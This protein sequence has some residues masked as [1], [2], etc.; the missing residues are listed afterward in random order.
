MTSREIIKRLKKEGW[1]L[2]HVKGSHHQ[3]KHPEKLGKITVPHPEKDFP[4]GTLKNIF[5]MA[6][7]D[8]PINKPKKL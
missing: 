5:R 1:I 2:H 3:F 4:V 6:G 7:W 8:N